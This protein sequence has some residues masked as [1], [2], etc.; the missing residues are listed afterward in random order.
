VKR[1]NFFEVDDGYSIGFSHQ[2]IPLWLRLIVGTPGFS[3]FGWRLAEKFGYLKVRPNP[4]KD[5]AEATFEK[6]DGMESRS[7]AYLA[8]SKRRKK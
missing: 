4:K 1:D 3:N 8:K 2:D 6:I 7:F 5:S